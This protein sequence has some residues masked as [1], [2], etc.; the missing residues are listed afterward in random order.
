MSGKKSYYLN[1]RT[2]CTIN[3]G[4]QVI[5]A[6]CFWLKYDTAQSNNTKINE[7]ILPSLRHREW[8]EWWWRLCMQRVITYRLSCSN[9]STTHRDTLTWNRERGRSKIKVLPFAQGGLG[10]VCIAWS[11]L[12]RSLHYFL[13]IYRIHFNCHENHKIDV[14]ESVHLDTIMKITN[15][16][17]YID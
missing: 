14:H 8:I 12:E 9:F 3:P 16:M 6:V 15:K 2:K 11:I 17:H 10:K 1:M 5:S 4:A 7:I 13:Y